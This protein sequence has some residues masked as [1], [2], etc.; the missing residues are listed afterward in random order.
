MP[1]FTAPYWTLLVFDCVPIPWELLANPQQALWQMWLDFHD[2]QAKACPFFL[3]LC[4]E[5]CYLRWR[6]K[7]QFADCTGRT[8]IETQALFILTTLELRMW[9]CLSWSRHTNHSFFFLR[10]WIFL[11]GWQCPASPAVNPSGWRSKPIVILTQTN[12]AWKC[13]TRMPLI[14]R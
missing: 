4:L 8:Y 10:L 14:S 11:S 13:L 6:F 12:R 7:E 9:N 3:C 2:V 5:M 1:V